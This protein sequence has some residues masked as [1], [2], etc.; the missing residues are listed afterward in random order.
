[1]AL[2]VVGVGIGCSRRGRARRTR[3]SARAQVA[4]C[5]EAR[6]L[7]LQE[8]VLGQ[9]VLELLLDLG[10]LDQQLLVSRATSIERARE[11]GRR[12]R[13][14]SGIAGSLQR[15]QRRRLLLL[16]LLLLLRRSWLRLG[17]WRL[18][19][20]LL[21]LLLRRCAGRRR[22]SLVRLGASKQRYLSG[23]TLK[24]LECHGEFVYPR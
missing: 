6:A 18:L 23:C 4:A 2:A 5:L 20:L 16:L 22:S 24:A 1:M 19:L 11:R 8:R 9:G 17:L 10:V 13:G 7:G 15:T 3:P 12:R 21:L 14:S